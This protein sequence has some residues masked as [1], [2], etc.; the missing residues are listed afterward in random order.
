MPWD[1]ADRVGDVQ[2]LWDRCFPDDSHTLKKK[3]EPVFFLAVAAFIT[4]QTA[5]FE[6]QIDIAA[7]VEWAVPES[8]PFLCEDSRGHAPP[9]I[10]PFMW[11]DVDETDPE[12]PVGK[13]PFQHEVVLDVFAFCLESVSAIPKGIKKV[14]PPRAALALTTVAAER[15]WKQW[16][17]GELIQTSF[18]D[19]FSGS[20][21]SLPTQEVL[22]SIDKLKPRTWKKILEGVAKFVRAHKPKSVRTKPF[23][24]GGAVWSGLSSWVIVGTSR[25]TAWLEKCSAEKADWQHDL[26]ADILH[27]SKAEILNDAQANTLAG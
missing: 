13:G 11:A 17:T 25:P 3:N 5:G 27:D 16:A 12:I 22:V 26:K 10:F 4:Q 19:K 7:Y 1:I 8:Q 23:Y 14:M 2:Q 15:A 21:W 9:P 6:T 18:D 20:M 24:T